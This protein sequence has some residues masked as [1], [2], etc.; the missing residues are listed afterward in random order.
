MITTIT[1]WE[2]LEATNRKLFK[3]GEAMWAKIAAE[4]SAS[5]NKDAARKAQAVRPAFKVKLKQK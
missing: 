3:L 5:S 2:K 1:D 4:R